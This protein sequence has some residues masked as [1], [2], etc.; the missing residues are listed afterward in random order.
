M[1]PPIGVSDSTTTIRPPRPSELDAVADA[2]LRDD[3]EHLT[4]LVAEHGGAARLAAVLDARG[5]LLEQ[6]LDRLSYHRDERSGET[7]G[8]VILFFDRGSNITVIAFLQALD[9]QVDAMGSP[10]RSRVGGQPDAE[11]G[12][13]VSDSD[14][15]FRFRVQH[16]ALIGSSG[17][18]A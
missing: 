5:L 2:R 17:S 12:R 6:R 11:I 15:A 1:E 16:R 18:L 9:G 13:R 7:L 14:F 10:I 4:V 3:S 8:A